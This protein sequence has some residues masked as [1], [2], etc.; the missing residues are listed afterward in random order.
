[1]IKLNINNSVRI[2]R[3]SEIIFWICK[4][5]RVVIKQTNSEYVLI[6]VSAP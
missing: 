3:Y 1:M 6:D 2:S 5:H 4:N